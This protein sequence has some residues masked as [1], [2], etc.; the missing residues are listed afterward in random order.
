MQICKRCV[1]PET[2]PNI[3]FDDKG[4]CSV[5]NAYDVRREKEQNQ[6]FQSQQ[7]LK[8]YLHELKDPKSRYDCLVALS[9]GV[10]SCN[11]LI[12]MIE[13]YELNPLGLHINHGYEPKTG[14]ENVQNLCD[15]YDVDLIIYRR[16]HEFMKKLWKYTNLSNMKGFTSCFFCGSQLYAN[17]LQVAD[18]FGIKLV[19]NGYSKGQGEVIT[20]SQH[21]DHAR[22][23]FSDL[24]NIIN[25]NDPDFLPQFLASQ[26]IFSKHIAV[27][28]KKDIENAE[29]DKILVFPFYFF[30]FNVQDKETLVKA[31]KERFDWKELETSW[32]ARTTNCEMIWLNS[33]MEFQRHGYTEYHEEYSCMIRA[34]DITREQAIQDLKFNPPPGLL[35][36]LAKD[37]DLD[38]SAIKH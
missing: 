5:C 11:T 37:I 23:M 10:D 36:R 31:C 6:V 28:T 18:N 25:I 30:D 8:S 1:L 4:I 2:F 35:E 32:P 7:E 13:Y 21:A 17:A 3:T 9:G 12:Q 38:L 34:G 14:Q 20:V 24:I 33:F 15:Y 16:D 22:S 19:F 29:P 26:S 27:G